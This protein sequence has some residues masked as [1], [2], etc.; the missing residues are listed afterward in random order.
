MLNVTD[1]YLL[2][3]K[4]KSIAIQY[5]LTFSVH[6]LRNFPGNILPYTF[7]CLWRELGGHQVGLSS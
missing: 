1:D 3:L 7:L 2:I 6:G 5:S 4:D